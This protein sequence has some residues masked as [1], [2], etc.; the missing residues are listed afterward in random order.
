MNSPQFPPRH[1][2]SRW[3]TDHAPLSRP[4]GGDCQDF[5]AINVH[6]HGIVAL[7]L[8]N[9]LFVIL[10]RRE[11]QTQV[12]CLAISRIL[13]RP[14]VDT[15]KSRIAIAKSTVGSRL[16]LARFPF[17]VIKIDRIKRGMEI[18]VV[19]GGIGPRTGMKPFPG[20]ANRNQDLST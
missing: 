16:V 8:E 14:D 9:Q 15:L 13:G 17:G 20:G 1:L 5:L 12:R 19:A 10:V 7:A 2:R 3:Q 11:L 4:P 18:L 6:N